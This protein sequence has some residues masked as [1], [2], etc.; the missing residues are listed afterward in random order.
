VEGN[1]AARHTYL[2]YPACFLCLFFSFYSKGSE[3]CIK[4]GFI[5]DLRLFL[6]ALSLYQQRTG[7]S[8][9]DGRFFS[10]S[11]DDPEL[12]HANSPCRA[13]TESR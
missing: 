11:H 3:Q 7:Y 13:H 4:F 6:T 5:P 8:R 9:L 12:W 10:V 2:G 1:D